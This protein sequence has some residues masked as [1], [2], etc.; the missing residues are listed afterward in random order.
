MIRQT[1]DRVAHHLDALTDV[2]AGHRQIEI[3][4]KTHQLLTERD[5]PQQGFRANPARGVVVVGHVHRAG[6]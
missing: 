2:Q 4:G 5:R 6:F 3:V 1:I